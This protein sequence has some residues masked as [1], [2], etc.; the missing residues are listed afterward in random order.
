[1]RAPEARGGWRVGV[2]QRGER[3]ALKLPHF[4]Q[5]QELFVTFLRACCGG[6][7]MMHSYPVAEGLEAVKQRGFNVGRARRLSRAL[8]QPPQPGGGCV[9]SDPRALLHAARPH[10]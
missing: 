6:S 8:T 3:C 10:L 5:L 1:M 9:G 4:V 7:A 2:A